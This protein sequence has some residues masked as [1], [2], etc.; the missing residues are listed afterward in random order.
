MAAFDWLSK[1][2]ERQ[3][4]VVTRAQLLAGITVDGE[5][6]PLVSAAQGIHKP[7]VL[8]LPISILTTPEVEG[9]P[10]PYDDAIE[11]SGLISYRYR[12][13]PQDI[14]HRDNEGLRTLMRRRLPLIYFVG[15]VRGEYLPQWPVY[16]TGDD[17]GAL[18]FTVAVDDY[19]VLR[20]NL[21][22]VGA[23]LAAEDAGLARRAYVT[24]VAK[25]RIHQTGFRIRVLRAYR[26][27]CTI[28]TLGHKEL[29]D[30]AHIIP[31]SE[32]EGLPLVTNGLA[33]CKL[34]HAAFD[35]GILGISPDYDIHVRMDILEEKDGPMLVHGL[36]EWQDRL[37]HPPRR[38]DLRPDR[39]LLAQR[40]ERFQSR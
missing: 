36:Q 8:D 33:L 6:I 20:P 27:R 3:G 13:G 40:F 22:D 25:R 11:D 21:T 24:T 10:R 17:P 5:H 37:I 38:S 28:C 23:S 4:E 29:L 35:Q 32:P 2:R 31:D 18:S 16:I 39:D 15:I 1:L 9:Q 12:G 26:E 30:A 34:H 7:R 19:G 14:H